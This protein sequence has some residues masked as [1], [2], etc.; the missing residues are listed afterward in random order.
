MWNLTMIFTSEAKGTD[1]TLDQCLRTAQALEYP[2]RPGYGP[3]K[4]SA[5]VGGEEEGMYRYF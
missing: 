4:P 2:G 3:H 5:Q 1:T